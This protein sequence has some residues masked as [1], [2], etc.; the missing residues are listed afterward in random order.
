MGH[1]PLKA[2]SGWLQ[3]EC[4]NVHRLVTV[5]DDKTKIEACQRHYNES[6]PLQGLQQLEWL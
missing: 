1:A 4:M 6:R 2:F 5:D 3:D